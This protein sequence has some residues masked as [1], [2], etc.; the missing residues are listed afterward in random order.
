[1]SVYSPK[2]FSIGSS[3]GDRMATF[4]HPPSGQAVDLILLGEEFGHQGRLG[5]LIRPLAARLIKGTR[6]WRVFGGTKMNIDTKNESSI[7]NIGKGT[8]T[9]CIY[10]SR[11]INPDTGH[12]MKA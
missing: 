5:R 8:G 4:R 9:G 3:L 7:L 12:E 11:K 1:M 10:K 2:Y 6:R